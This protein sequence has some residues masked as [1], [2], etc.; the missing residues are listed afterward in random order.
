MHA[1]R[2]YF[3]LQ[4]VVDLGIILQNESLRK[5]QRLGHALPNKQELFGSVLLECVTWEI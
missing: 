4:Y 3:F 1:F 2:Q 5:T